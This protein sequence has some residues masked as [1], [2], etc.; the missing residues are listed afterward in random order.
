MGK[1][2]QELVFFLKASDLKKITDKAGDRMTGLKLSLGIDSKSKLSIKASPVFK[3]SGNAKT[4]SGGDPVAFDAVP[5]PPGS[6]I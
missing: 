3:S 4:R 6:G 5:N 1:H 2:V